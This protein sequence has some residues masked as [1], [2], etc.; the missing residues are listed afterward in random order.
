MKPQ[1]IK[2][3]PDQL[4]PTYFGCREKAIEKFLQSGL[5]QQELNRSADFREAWTTSIKCSKVI[6]GKL[7]EHSTALTV[8][9]DE[10][11]PFLTDFTKAV[12]KL[13][14]NATAF[15][16]Q[17]Q[18][19]SFYFLLMDLMTKA[20]PD[21]CR[22]GFMLAEKGVKN[23][24]SVRFESFAKAENDISQLQ[25]LEGEIV[26]KITSCFYVG[27]KICNDQNTLILSP[28]EVFTVESVKAVKD[29]SNG[30]YTL[31]VLNHQSVENSQDCSTFSR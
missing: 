8:F 31:I 1:L 4:V 21:Q 30:D 12:K 17:F 3:A 29:Y 11:K 18:F 24:S 22:T 19:K 16:D 5:L 6:P 26:L 28:A 15:E 27:T 23:G 10:D 25:D 2:W 9:Q 7:K 13:S 20:L 14:V